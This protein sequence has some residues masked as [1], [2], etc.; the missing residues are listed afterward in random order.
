MKTKHNGIAFAFES[1]L[2]L[3]FQK[4]SVHVKKFLLRQLKI[5]NDLSY[6]FSYESTI[7]LD[8]NDS[9][10]NAFYC[11]LFSKYANDIS[12]MYIVLSNRLL[13]LID[14]F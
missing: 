13:Q 4:I 14:F 5:L 11:R 3:L 7:L 10:E 6:F 12:N 1:I 2:C 8:N 9:F